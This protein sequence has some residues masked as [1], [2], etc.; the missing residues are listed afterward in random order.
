MEISQALTQRR[1]VKRY[2][3]E[4]AIPE[5]T[6]REILS[7]AILSPTA[8]NIQHWR[9]VWVRDP[10]QRRRIREV[11]WNQEK[12]TE[13]SVLLVLTADT[14]AWEPH[15]APRYYE[16]AP[17]AVIDYAMPAIDAYYRGKPQVERDECFRSMGMAAMSIMLLATDYGYD[18]CPMVGFDFD[19][20]GR[21]INLPKDHVVGMMISIGRRTK[22]PYPRVGKL[23]LDEVL[24]IDRFEQ[25]Q[26]DGK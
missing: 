8:F 3:E 11:G 16:G 5:A 7:K 12:I 6:V 22:D 9:F 26:D 13:A 14:K 24:I 1:A 19:A 10:E 23:P 20:V 17:Q 4:Y 2:D 15:R 18:C 21:L 25:G